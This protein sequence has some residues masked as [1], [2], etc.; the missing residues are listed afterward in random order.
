MIRRAYFRS[1]SAA[2]ADER[3]FDGNSELSD[4]VA[5][6]LAL[7][8]PAEKHELIPRLTDM[9]SACKG[10]VEHRGKL[11]AICPKVRGTSWPLV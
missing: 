7:V 1:E 2:L 5:A 4:V 3:D 11:G 9:V 8:L 10:V 6:L